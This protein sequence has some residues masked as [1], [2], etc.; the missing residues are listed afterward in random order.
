M[1]VI[2]HGFLKHPTIGCFLKPSVVKTP[3]IN[4]KFEITT[5][6]KQQVSHQGAEKFQTKQGF[7]G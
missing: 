5:K 1:F 7:S 3:M 6:Q 4:H 2:H